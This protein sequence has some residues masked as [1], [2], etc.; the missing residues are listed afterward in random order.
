[1]S[2]SWRRST[3]DNS[4]AVKTRTGMWKIDPLGKVNSTVRISKKSFMLY[5]LVL[6]EL[7]P[8]L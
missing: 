4:K 2:A 8:L 1:M 6:I 3:P 7:E 5:N